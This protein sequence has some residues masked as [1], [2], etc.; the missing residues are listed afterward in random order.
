MKDLI[1]KIIN[2]SELSEEDKINFIEKIINASHEMDNIVAPGF[3]FHADK[4]QE[5]GEIDLQLWYR[6]VD[7][8]GMTMHGPTNYD[9]NRII[10]MMKQEYFNQNRKSK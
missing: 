4:N 8:S 5:N 2:D 3:Y 1:S 7:E 10:Q 9:N 6:N